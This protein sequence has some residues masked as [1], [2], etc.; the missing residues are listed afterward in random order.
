M[1]PGHPT[2]TPATWLKAS[3][4]AAAAGLGA[5]AIAWTLLLAWTCWT[6]PDR[7]GPSRQITVQVLTIATA[8][9]G[10]VLWQATTAHVLWRAFGQLA[11]DRATGD[12]I[13]GLAAGNSGG[14]RLVDGSRR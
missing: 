3:I 6:S 11:L 10:A 9:T 13:T 2:T 4:A 7:L 8:L 14:P 5:C 12:T 1:N